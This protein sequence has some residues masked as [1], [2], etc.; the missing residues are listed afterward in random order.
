MQAG[1][2]SS[3]D[4]F[5]VVLSQFVSR[6]IDNPGLGGLILL[7]VFR[8]SLIAGVT[9]GRSVLHPC[10]RPAVAPRPLGAISTFRDC[11]S[12]FRDYVAQIV[13]ARIDR[14]AIDTLER[15]IE[16]NQMRAAYVAQTSLYGYLKTRMGSKYVQLFQDDVFVISINDAKWTVFASC[17]ADLT[18]FSCALV[19]R[20]GPLEPEAAADLA[21]HCFRR[22]VEQTFAGDAL[23][24]FGHPAIEAFQPRAR[25]TIWHEA[26]EGENAFGRSPADL[27]ARAPVIDEFKALDAEIVV[28]S[29]RFRWRDVRVQLRRR[30]D[31]ASI[32]RR[33]GE[34][35]GERSGSSR[36]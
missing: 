35:D 1:G 26:A 29:M 9:S 19:H 20:D 16:F 32:A 13:K 28:N 11:V 7:P 8:S 21:I 5:A 24:R 17:L 34:T 10:W 14:R 25:L 36:D 22:A 30:L 15:L 2:P 18:V 27:I 33:W 23:T 6:L 12:M 3:K 31:G 4:R